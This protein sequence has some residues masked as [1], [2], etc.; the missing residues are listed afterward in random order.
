MPGYKGFLTLRKAG[1]V[2]TTRKL[3]GVGLVVGLWVLNF[4]VF[5]AFFFF[6]FRIDVV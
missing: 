2:G 6:G 3:V 5:F 1:A 4:R